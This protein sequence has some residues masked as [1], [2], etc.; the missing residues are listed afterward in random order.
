MRIPVKAPKKS[1]KKIFVV[2]DSGWELPDMIWLRYYPN[3]VFLS[4]SR[5]EANGARWDKRI[6][7]LSRIILLP[8]SEVAC[9]LERSAPVKVI[10]S[11]TK[12]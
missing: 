12:S 3:K 6:I 1:A 10:I 2:S 8:A 11:L 5:H 9:S 7:M 4:S